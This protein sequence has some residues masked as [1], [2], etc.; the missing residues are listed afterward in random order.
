MKKIDI[1]NKEKPK[2][3]KIPEAKIWN[4]YIDGKIS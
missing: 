4:K 1:N 3:I 2:T